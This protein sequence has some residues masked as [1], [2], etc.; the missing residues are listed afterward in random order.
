M[1]RNRPHPP[2]SPLDA[3]RL[4]K[5]LRKWAHLIE[6]VEDDRGSQNGWWVYLKNGFI[7]PPSETHQIHETT[8][9]ECA[10]QLAEV[11]PC[12]CAARCETQD[13]SA[14]LIAA[15]PE[16]LE[17]CKRVLSECCA[18]YVNPESCGIA[19]HADMRAAIAKA[20]RHR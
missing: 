2:A 3:E 4:P 8:L 11:A 7:N 10:R 1:K 14:S 9:A 17:V 20:E 18:R 13:A 5:T 19:L 15:A 6:D 16:L 12:A